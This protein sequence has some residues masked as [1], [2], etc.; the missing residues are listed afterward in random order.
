MISIY[1]LLNRITQDC[2]VHVQ[3]CTIVHTKHILKGHVTQS[4]SGTT[5]K[6]QT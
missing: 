1:V 5:G 3:R 6:I 4:V 2:L